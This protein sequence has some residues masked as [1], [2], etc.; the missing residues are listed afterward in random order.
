LR[1]TTDQLSRGR[2][3]ARCSCTRRRLL[4]GASLAAAWCCQAF[5]FDTTIDGWQVNLDTT[6][7]SSVDM[8]ASPIDRNFVGRANGGL[9]SDQ[10]ADNGTLNYKD[11]TPVAA[12]QRITTE[13]QVK[14]DDYGVFVRATGF[15]DPVIDSE[16]TDFQKLSR[17]AVRDI[18]ADL[19]LLD[20]YAFASP[21]IFGHSVDFRVGAQ[22]LNWG[23]STFIPFGI[24]SINPLDLTALRS[25]GAETRTAFLPIPVV[26]ARTE[27]GGGFSLEGFWQFIWTRDKIEPNGSFFSNLDTLSDG[28]TYA[29][30]R[31][32]VADSARSPYFVNIPGGDVLGAAYPRSTDRH[33]SSLDQFGFALRKTFDNIMG[34]TE[35]GL[36]FENYHSR[37]PFLSLHTGVPNISPGSSPFAPIPLPTV[38]PNP[39]YLFLLQTKG[40]A[41][42]T[43]D[44][45]ANYFADYPSDI[46][47]IGASFNFTGPAGIAVQGEF[48]HRLNQPIQLSGSDLTLLNDI[49]ALRQLASSPYIGALF[50]GAYEAAIH[51]PVLLALGE[52]PEFNT[53]IDGWKRYHVSQFQ[54]TATK[55]FSA[56]PSLGI[57]SIALIGEIGFDFV[58]N[59]P[60]QR[61]IFNAP[62][63]TDTNSVFNVFATV[64][65]NGTTPLSTT[66]GLASQF[67]GAY[68][69]ASIIDMPNILPYG[70]DMK[71]SV[72][73]QHDF[74]GTSPVGVNVFVEN[75]AAASV[76]VTFNYL[77]AWS[78]GMQYTNHFPVFA[79]GKFYGLLDRD[80]YSATL[81][82]EF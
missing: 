57:N 51:D 53:T 55:L 8:R 24:N 12:L 39:N 6:L 32:D 70:I 43:Y 9:F 68:T 58:H 71:P 41:A 60:R 7:S 82:Y 33:P 34:G 23:E 67:S 27:V 31:N 74:V 65:S 5:A 40:Y 75:T 18:G 80:F 16:Q 62:Y 4:A 35:V 37:L 1:N 29:M 20:A 22:A 81:S 15:Y 78:F 79:G 56:I 38:L 52:S 54:M 13:L 45:T 28:S 73:L 17:A 26:D 61:G 14:R 3:P 30:L 63:T 10:N 44:S 46:H 42:K 72:S 76:G 66:K 21:K 77:Q 69:I 25:P 50:K 11:N 49:P 47:L 48:S 59:F 19:R 36:Y 64:N 2:R